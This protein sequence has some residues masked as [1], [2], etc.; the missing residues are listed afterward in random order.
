MARTRRGHRLRHRRRLCRVGATP[1]YAAQPRH[2]DRGRHVPCR[3][4]GLHRRAAGAVGIGALVR[5]RSSTSA[6][7]SSPVSSAACSASA[8]RP[9]GSSRPV[10]GSQ[11]DLAAG[12]RRRHHDAASRDRGRAPR[13]RGDRSTI[14]A[15]GVSNARPRRVRRRGPCRRSVGGRDHRHVAVAG[16]ADRCGDHQSAGEH[17][18]VGPHDG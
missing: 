7:C 11:S 16:T 15:T 9:A 5:R 6:S 12:P 8:C 13:H 2:G 17:G 3:P 14:H 10:H 4:S 1:G 18:R